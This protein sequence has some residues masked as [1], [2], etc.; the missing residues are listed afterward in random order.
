MQIKHQTEPPWRLLCVCPRRQSSVGRLRM[1]SCS[2]QI[3]TEPAARGEWPYFTGTIAESGWA[4]RHW[5]YAAWSGPFSPPFA[6]WQVLVVFGRSCKRDSPPR[7]THVIIAAGAIVISPVVVVSFVVRMFLRPHD[8]R[9]GQCG[10]QYERARIRK[11]CMLLFSASPIGTPLAV[12]AF[13]GCRAT[14]LPPASIARWAPGKPAAQDGGKLGSFVVRI[15]D[16][17]SVYGSTARLRRKHSAFSRR[18][19]PSASVSRAATNVGG[20]VI[21]AGNPRLPQVVMCKSCRPSGKKCLLP[22]VSTNCRRT[23]SRQVG[24]IR[25]RAVAMKWP[26]SPRWPPRQHVKPNW[27][28][29]RVVGPFS[30]WRAGNSARSRLFSRLWAPKRRLRPTLAALQ[31]QTDP[32]LAAGHVP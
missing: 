1:C 7:S 12:R 20:L 28:R 18:H 3:C 16:R 13:A 26:A 24:D 8:Y 27:A 14:P 29:S 17:I 5:K 31:N 2:W 25:L 30:L 4:C 19:S 10:A 32:L 23:C 9:S 21:Q 11:R 6:V 15:R 22:A